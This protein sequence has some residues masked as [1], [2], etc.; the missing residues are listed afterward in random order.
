MSKT[1]STAT[2]TPETGT[3]AGRET[4]TGTGAGTDVPDLFTPLRLGP[5]ALSNRIVMAP[6]TRNRAG[7]GDAPT[8][9]NV[10]YYRQR[11]SAGMIVTEG[12]QVS[13]RGKGYPGTPGIHSAAQ[14]AGWR[15]VTD[16]VH[17][18]G[19]RIFLQLWHVGRISH[20]SLQPGGAR[21][22]APSALRPEGEVFTEDGK[23]PFVTPR[24]LET[25]EIPVVVGEFRK[26]ARNALAAGFDGVEVHAANGYLLDQFLRDGTNRRTDRY[27]GPVENRARLLLE[28]TKAVIDV[29]GA[30]RVGV[31]LSPVN[32]FND[33]ADSDPDATFGYAASELGKLGI[34]FLHVVES[35]FAGSTATRTFDK[36]KLR[37]A[38]DGLYLANGGYDKTRATEALAQGA[39]DF[40]SFG[41]PY[42]AN[43]DL[44][45]RFA[46][47]APLNAPDPETFYGGDE[48]GYT[49]YPA[50]GEGVLAA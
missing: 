41:A 17:Q 42:V 5:Y 4:G 15:K 50:L 31:R 24:A 2:P 11:A 14:I 48:R 22:V 38:F 20:P 46:Q 37:Q 28:V 26:A 49:D 30:E 1:S 36:Q 45:E 7:A 9:M 18:E 12:S 43:P 35:D 16:A 33:I 21:P 13:P 44:V 10:E 6:L 39:A 8:G 29:W 3:E 47:G 19:G 32:T 25:D 27:G 23:Q 34:A 40:V